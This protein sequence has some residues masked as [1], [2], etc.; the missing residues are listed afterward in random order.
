M[1]DFK[2]PEGPP[3][4]RSPLSGTK[5]H[6]SGASP[7][8]AIPRLRLFPGHRHSSH[9]GS[10][11]PGPVIGSPDDLL[12]R[13]Q[14]LESQVEDA[15]ARSRVQPGGVGQDLL[16]EAVNTAFGLYAELRHRVAG[17]GD[18]LVHLRMLGRGLAVDDYGYDPAAAKWIEPILD[19][20]FQYWWRVSVKNIERVPA[21]GPVVLVANH[22]GALLPYDA[23]MI[24]TALR[25]VHPAHRRARPLVEDYLYYWPYVG[26][27]LARIGA[28]RADRANARR[29]LASGSAIIV[30]PE[31]ARGLSKPYRDR[32][33]IERFGR[34]DF[35]G[36]CLEAGAVLV[37]V[38]VIGAE[39][40]HPVV[41]RATGVGRLLGLPYLPITPTFPWLGVLGLVPLPTKWTI[42]FGEPIDLAGRNDT[43]NPADPAVVGRI[44]EQVRQRIQ[45]MVLEGLRRRRSIFFG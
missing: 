37:P 31:G 10:Q 18:L 22:G 32:Y 29:L 5:M 17:M 24:S 45:R 42:R 34:G 30:F 44:R 7:E 14:T 28:V 38:S 16:I 8:E 11:K 4:S 15:L 27:L 41:A 36:L 19:V 12:V 23:L 9:E 26:T 20:L 39:E 13:L 21:R 43:P 25:C 3:E 1:A 33:R 6:E 2:A 35:V 40:T